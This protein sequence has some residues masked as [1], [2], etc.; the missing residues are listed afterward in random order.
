MPGDRF[1]QDAAKWF[2][3]DGPGVPRLHRDNEVKTYVN[4]DQAYPEMVA[5]I[6]TA[7]GDGHFVYLLNWFLDVELALVPGKSLGVLPHA[8]NDPPN[9]PRIGLLNQASSKGVM[10]RAM[11]WDQVFSSANSKDVDFINLLKNGAAILDS[12]GNAGLPFQNIPILSLLAKI[13]AHFG[14]QHQK[15]LCVFGEHGLITFC[16]GLDFN[17]DRLQANGGGTPLHDVHCRVR[18]TAALDLLQVFVQRWNDHPARVELE[19]KKKPLLS[20]KAAPPSA[21][22]HLVRIG[23]TLGKDLYSFAQGGERTA[24]E[25]ILRGI[26]GARRFIYTEC[27][28]FIGNPELEAALLQALSNGI[29]HFTAVV[30]HW[31]LSD[32]PTVQKHRREFFRRLKKAGGDRVRIFARN[33]DPFPLNPLRAATFIDPDDPG[34]KDIKKYTRAFLDGKHPRTY[35]HSKT[36]VMDDEF[37]VIGSLNSNRRSWSHDSEVCAGFYDE[38][39]DKI[40]TYRLAHGLRIRLWQEHLGMTGKQGETELADGVASAVHWLAGNR[41]P[42]AQVQDYPAEELSDKLVPIPI[43]GPLVNDEAL[44]KAV[45]DPD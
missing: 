10:V 18:G 1:A 2:Q 43:L 37:G 33:P 27:Q 36:W 31:R 23:R 35:V 45:M 30:T 9:P 38:S 4:A 19:K 25:I 5:A 3:P 29:Q 32:L 6:E 7:T 17:P 12:T 22:P 15:I 24:R 44:F 20:M 26:L 41:P 21:G 28:Y 40:L 14:S 39:S 8:A 11:A 42:G 16:G 34:D 13:P